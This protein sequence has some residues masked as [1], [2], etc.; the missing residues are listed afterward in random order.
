MAAPVWHGPRD[1]SW[2]VELLDLAGNI[3]PEALPVKSGSGSLDWQTDRAST[4][5]GKVALQG[6]INLP[7]LL[8]GRRLRPVYTLNGTDYPQGVYK[9]GRTPTSHTGGGNQ[10]HDVSLTDAAAITGNTVG[11]VT[12]PVATNI[13]V[14]VRAIAAAQ[15]VPVS[16]TNT[17]ATLRTE[18]SWPDN[19]PWAKVVAEMLEAA[20]HTPL[21]ANMAGMLQSRPYTPAQERAV[22]YDFRNNAEGIYEPRFSTDS[23]WAT[24]PNRFR[25]VARSGAGAD[26]L[27]GYASDENPL[28]PWSY[29]ARGEWVEEVGKD[30]DA[31]SQEA[32]NL[33][34]ARM[35]AEAQQ[36]AATLT[37]QCAWIPQLKLGAV[38]GF[39]NTKHAMSGLWEITAMSWPMTP[40][41]RVSVTA[42]SVA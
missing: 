19:T 7:A 16:V 27:V 33:I 30:V 20:G 4:G 15:D 32:L 42:R 34:A 39:H 10:T 17:G 12:Y 6:V 38:V 21:A 31:A 35:L 8:L 18:M 25:V 1:A 23:N 28:S 26:A 40:T 3:L 9:A 13:A 37:F 36:A 11:S 14:Q 22:V 24:I 2:R 29:P 5:A 41:A